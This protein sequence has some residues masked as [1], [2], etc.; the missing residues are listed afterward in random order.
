M[1]PYPFVFTAGAKLGVLGAGGALPA[2]KNLGG[3]LAR[4]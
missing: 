2:R 4:C 3:L 1:I